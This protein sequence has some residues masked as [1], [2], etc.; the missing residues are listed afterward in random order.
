MLME[1]FIL[2]LLSE[3]KKPALDN[4]KLFKQVANNKSIGWV[5]LANILR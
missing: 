5:K 1:L 3:V 4:Y 2:R